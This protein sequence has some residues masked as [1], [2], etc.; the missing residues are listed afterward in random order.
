[1]AEFM[2]VPVAE[3]RPNPEQPRRE[4]E[5]GP[6]EELAASIAEH[7]VITPIEVERNGD[8]YILHAGERR[9]RA[10]KMAG[11]QTIPATVTEKMGERERLERA[12]VENVQREDMN[13]IEEAR[14]YRRLRDEFG[15]NMIQ[16]ARRVGRAQSTIS[17]RLEWL[18]FDEEIVAL[19][20]S[21]ALHSDRRVQAALR[22]VPAETRVRFANRMAGNNFTIAGIEKAA[23]VMASALERTE[24]PSRK[25]GPGASDC[26]K[27]KEEAG[28][29]HSVTLVLGDCAVPGPAG[30]QLEAAA[31]AACRACGM[32]EHR[33][34]VVCEE[35]PA[36]VMLRTYVQGVQ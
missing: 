24:K 13:P 12:I 28:C 10:A 22:K 32:F 21:G 26:R 5:E 17:T 6:L 15:L 2:D 33:P 8:G 14:A 36:T 18:A 23:K 11:L 1:M 19:V 30:G 25:F 31:L 4:F 16:I 29:A 27:R 9:W 20:E 7:G 35:C 3:I 34:G